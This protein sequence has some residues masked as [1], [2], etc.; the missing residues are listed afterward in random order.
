MAGS[1]T[2]LRTKCRAFTDQWIKVM[3]GI[4]TNPRSTDRDR[5]A[6]G[7]AL[8]DRGW[9]KAETTNVSIKGDIAS[10]SDAE[11]VAR[12]EQLR[13]DRVMGGNPDETLN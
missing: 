2:E 13:K 10:M 5:I 9:G 1:P 7:N 8:M 12:L 11:L 6:A 3:G 4:L